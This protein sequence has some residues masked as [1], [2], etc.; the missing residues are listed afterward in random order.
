MHRL[1]STLV[2]SALVAIPALA[3][4]VK[5]ET[6]DIKTGTFSITFGGTLTTALDAADISFKK[7]QPARINPGKGTITYV[8]TGGAIDLINAKTEIV[9]SGGIT[10]AKEIVPPT[11][12]PTAAKEPKEFLT[13]TI[14][15]PII[16]LS[17]SGVEPAVK[18]V[19]AIVVVNGV[20]KGRMHIFNIVG[21]VFGGTPLI[22]PKNKKITALDLS[23]S[24]TSDGATELNN[25]LGVTA[26][27]ADTEVATAKIDVK[28]AS[29]NL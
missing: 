11:I 17:E 12:S 19:S 2:L 1:L 20:S 24:L 7:A 25:A 4:D 6:A 18:E 22:V 14:L 13:A 8:T 23:L 27:A 21:T 9:H 10:L 26:F 16:E 3:V 5:R 28:L 29:S 15:D